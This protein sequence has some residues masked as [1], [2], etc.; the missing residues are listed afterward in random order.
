MEIELLIDVEAEPAARAL[1]IGGP[2][3]LKE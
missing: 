1:I 2:R 3:K